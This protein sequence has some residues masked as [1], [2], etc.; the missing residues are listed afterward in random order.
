MWAASS[1]IRT[2]SEARSAVGVDCDARNSR[3]TKSAG[4]SNR[5]LSRFATS[6]FRIFIPLSSIALTRERFRQVSPGS[7]SNSICFKYSGLFYDTRITVGAECQT[8]CIR[9]GR[10]GGEQ[11][12]IIWSAIDVF[13]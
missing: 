5:D 3:F 6:T 8:S 9:L 1:A 4:N 10:R 7:L 12:R 2:W 11:I 13:E